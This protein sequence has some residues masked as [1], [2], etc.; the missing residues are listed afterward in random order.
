MASP[1][2]ATPD[3]LRLRSEI[4]AL[5]REI[6][7]TAEEL[8][9]ERRSTRQL[10][11]LANELQAQSIRLTKAIV[12]GE[13]FFDFDFLVCPRCG[14]PIL[15][16]RA[17]E[18][19]CYLCLQQEPPAPTRSELVREQDRVN[20]QIAETEELIASHDQRAQELERIV[21][22]LR[23]DRQKVGHLLDQE[24][25]GF[26]SDQAEHIEALAREQVV[27]GERIQRLEDYLGLFQKLDAA[28]SRISQ[29]GQKRSDLEAALERAEQLDTIS[30]GRIE[31][32]EQ[33]FKHFV[34][35]L[36]IPR[37]GAGIRAAIDRNDYQPIVNGQKFPGLS[38]GVRVLVNI[39]HILAHHRTAR[40]LGLLLPELIMID[41]IAKNIGTSGYDAARIEDIWRALMALTEDLEESLQLIVATND[42]PDYLEPYVRLILSETDRLIPTTD[43]KPS[44]DT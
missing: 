40:D 27:L 44:Q 11:E 33:W 28:L 43:I 1:A 13:R 5:E 41:G 10:A 39:A 25:E 42:V 17:D 14:S 20:S 21:G 15:P 4:V 3:A 18:G 22:A 6:T 34:E 7:D 26:I 24:V 36:E 2:Q 19:H 31:R 38:A 16:N 29:L 30:A 9:N 12:A 37:F 8:E 23:S 32:L 35:A